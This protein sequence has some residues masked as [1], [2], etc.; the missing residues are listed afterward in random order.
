MWCA[1]TLALRVIEV[2]I[3]TALVN[4][5]TSPIANSI[6]RR[7]TPVI[8]NSWILRNG[9]GIIF[10]F[11]ATFARASIIIKVLILVTS[12]FVNTLAST[13]FLIPVLV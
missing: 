2:L 4:R 10:S 6:D 7:G 8:F 11:W 13:F 9:R 12:N 1:E 3:R 5:V